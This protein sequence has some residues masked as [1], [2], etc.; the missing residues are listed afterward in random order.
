[1]AFVN[2]EISQEDYDKYNIEKFNNKN[3]WRGGSRHWTIDRDRDIWFRKFRKFADIENDGAEIDTTWDFY[4]KRTLIT[5][6]TKALKRGYLEEAKEY[7]AHIKIL[8]IY[9]TREENYHN[10]EDIEHNKILVDFPEELEEHKQEILKDLK[11]VF[12]ASN[13]GNGIYS[14]ANGYKI[15]L[16]YE[17]ELV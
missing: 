13:G 15:D 12:E 3:G 17:G 8:D 5:I 9:T 10:N 14:N 16:E 7:Y 4:W 6:V 11:E 2:E 1:M